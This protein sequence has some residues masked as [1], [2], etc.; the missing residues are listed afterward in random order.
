MHRERRV[1]LLRDY[2]AVRALARPAPSSF[3]VI[4]LLVAAQLALAGFVA[5]RPWWLLLLVAYGVGAA[6]V[7][8]LFSMI[9][10]ASHGL[11][12]SRRGGNRL[13]AYLA[14]VPILFPAAE[15]FLEHH[16]THH[17]GLGAYEGDVA[18]PREWEVR[19]VGASPWR[20]AAWLAL[21]PIIYA[22]RV[23]GMKLGAG[24]RARADRARRRSRRG[25]YVAN[26]LLQAAC[27]GLITQAWGARA[28]VYLLLSFLCGFGLHPLNAITLQEH[29]PA[30]VRQVTYSYYGLG[31][32]VSF[33]S[34]YHYEHHDLP[35]V[36]WCRLP[37]LRRA[38]PEL[39]ASLHSH[40]SWVGLWLR[41]LTDR[42][43]TLRGQARLPWRRA[44]RSWRSRL[45]GQ[46]WSPGQVAG[47]G[48]EA[49]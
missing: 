28:L 3:V 12:F 31:N 23:R 41:F 35:T 10:E 47:R 17:G 26:A 34:G 49:A 22:L 25:W 44:R 32:L 13:A 6:L 42:E 46:A 40:P 2:P 8:G 29:L 20:K 7:V 37:A 30:R 33:N 43:Y 18:I 45:R 39:Y 48:D 24:R 15:T 11:I 36:P 16:H 9:H 19:W 14:N 1:V 38:A 4:A 5:S 21:Y 27:V